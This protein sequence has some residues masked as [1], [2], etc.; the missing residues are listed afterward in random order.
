MSVANHSVEVHQKNK[1]KIRLMD[2][3]HEQIKKRNG[4]GIN[5]H[6]KSYINF[7]SKLVQFSI[8][9]NLVF[10][11][12][13]SSSLIRL[14]R[15]WETSRVLNII[16]KCINGWHKAYIQI[17]DMNY[18]FKSIY[19]YWIIDRWPTIIIIIFFDHHHYCL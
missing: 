17:Y 2:L 7:F 11:E 14:K 19:Q 8:A 5:Y 12:N 18:N 9:I 6:Q 4:N 10:F 1:K 13:R 3:M 15:K 16:N